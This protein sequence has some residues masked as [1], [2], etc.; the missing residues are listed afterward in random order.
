MHRLWPDLFLLL[1]RFDFLFAEEANVCMLT[2]CQSWACA[3]LDTFKEDNL[4]SKIRDLL[5]RFACLETTD[6]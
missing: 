2:A 3:T 1:G 5:F 4:D 6:S